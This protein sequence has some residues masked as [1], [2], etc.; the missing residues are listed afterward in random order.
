M[1]TPNPLLIAAHFESL[2]DPRISSK[3]EHKLLD[4]R[5]VAMVKD[6]CNNLIIN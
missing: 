1:S 2:A 3:T 4:I 5:V 6:S